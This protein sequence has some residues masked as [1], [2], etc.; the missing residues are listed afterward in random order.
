[1]KNCI[2]EHINVFLELG[3]VRITFFVA[4]ST[5][6]GYVL[7]SKVINQQVVFVAL[8]VFLLA[9]AS[10]AMNHF[11][12]RKSDALM[13]RTKSRPIPSGKITPVYALVFSIAFGIIG[14]LI[15]FFIAGYIALYLGWLAFFWYN[16]VYT[17][18]KRKYALAVIPG[19]LIGAIPPVIGWVSSGGEISDPQIVA[20]ALFFFIWQIPHFWLLLMLHNN[21]YKQAGFPTLTEVFS[22][23][24]LGRITYIWIVALAVSCLL[25][26]LFSISKS[27]FAISLLMLSSIMLLFKTKNILST[28][29]E[30][31]IFR[32]AFLHLNL[33]VLIVVT[34][35]SI[36][37]LLL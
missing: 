5:S 17:P 2:S 13:E 18:L 21:D 22:N 7:Y 37:K 15:L 16:A 25:I 35:L 34:I 6:V 26:P 14:S 28:I 12:E 9:I 1:M 29:N 33:F 36:E 20:F 27:Y 30:R 32:K 24:Q 23:G 31:K 8:G 10:S 11:Q 3:K 19:S 4:I